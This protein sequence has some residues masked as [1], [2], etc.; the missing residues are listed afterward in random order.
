MLGNIVGS[1]IAWA[2]GY[3]GRVELLE[4]NR[5]IHIN[6]KHL[7][8]ADSWFQRYGDI[9]V[10]VTRCLPIIR[11][12]ISLPA[13]VARMPFWRF[14]LYTAIG[15]VPWVLMLGLIGQEVGDELGGVARLPPLRRLPRARRDRRAHR[16]SGDPAAARQAAGPS[17]RAD[18]AP[19]RARPEPAGSPPGA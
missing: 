7:D 6:K 5:F 14:T 10:L 15:C 13:G 4:Q 9:T 16:L 11:T 12:F 18:D 2:V 1:W 3:Y 8:W 19:R 17:E